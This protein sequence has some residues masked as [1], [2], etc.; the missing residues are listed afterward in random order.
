MPPLLARA[1]AWVTD[2]LR[3]LWALARRYPVRAA[4]VLP[5]LVLLYV[6]AVGVRPTAPR[7]LARSTRLSTK[8]L[9]GSAT[10]DPLAVF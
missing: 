3:R 8:S 10:I 4:L 7:G 2:L 9:H 1:L 5:A 6:L